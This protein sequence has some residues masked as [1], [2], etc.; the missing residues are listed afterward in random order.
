MTNEKC[1]NIFL[2]CGLILSI[3]IFMAII[4][5]CSIYLANEQTKRTNY[6]ELTYYNF[7]ICYDDDNYCYEIFTDGKKYEIRESQ[8]NVKYDDETYIVIFDNNYKWQY[9]KA[10]LFIGIKGDAK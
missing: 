7:E 4:V 2:I 3:C 10:I 6:D 5:S 1:K 8:F 9:N